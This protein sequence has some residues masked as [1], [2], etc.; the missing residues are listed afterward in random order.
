VVAAAER[1]VA[2]LLQILPSLGLHL[3]KIPLP[4]RTYPDLPLD[5]RSYAAL[6]EA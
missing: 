1:V 3:H 6:L 5:P 4:V 2:L